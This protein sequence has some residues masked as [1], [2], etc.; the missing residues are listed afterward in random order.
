MIK[1][2]QRKV[3]IRRKSSTHFE[4]NRKSCA[5]FS[6]DDTTNIIETDKFHVKNFR[7]FVS[8]EKIQR[9]FCVETSLLS[10]TNAQRR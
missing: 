8:E 4:N 5:S 3:Q 9:N 6:A 10:F 7:P 2:A 1:G